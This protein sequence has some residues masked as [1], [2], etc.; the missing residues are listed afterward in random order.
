MSDIQQDKFLSIPGWFNFSDIYRHAVK[1]AESG[2]HFVEIGCWLGRSTVFMGTEILNSGKDIR[3]DAIDNW[4]GSSP[5]QLMYAAKNDVYQ[6]FLKNIKGLPI[7]P[8]RMDSLEA[9]KRY[10]DGSLD[11]VFIDAS[12]DY[13]NVKADGEAWLPK[14]KK[15]G[16]IA[17]HDYTNS[18]PGLI[19]AVKEVFKNYD[20]I[21]SSWIVKV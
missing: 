3:F 20:V 11:F 21:N 19:R 10:K 18:Y 1:T 14:V 16:V 8:V 15:G 12:H 5:Q 17:G 6:E 4:K 7:N 9:V 2:A 13:V